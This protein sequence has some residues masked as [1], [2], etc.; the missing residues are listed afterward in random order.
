MDVARIYPARARTGA[1]DCLVRAAAGR[2]AWLGGLFGGANF[3]NIDIDW[4]AGELALTLHDAETGDAVRSAR[5]TLL[6]VGLALPRKRDL[7]T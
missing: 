6:S 1:P 2:R 3:G 7:T 4:S 5:I